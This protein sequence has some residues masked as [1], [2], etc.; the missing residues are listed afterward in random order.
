MLNFEGLYFNI[1]NSK[2]YIPSLKMLNDE[3][4]ML[5][6]EVMYFNIQNSKLNVPS[7]KMLI[8]D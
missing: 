2:L 6:F 1:Q 8:V 5:N 4:R 7:L 3:Q